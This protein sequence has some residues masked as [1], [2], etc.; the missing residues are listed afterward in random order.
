MPRTKQENLQDKDH[1]LLIRIDEQIKLLLQRLSTVEMALTNNNKLFEDLRLR[2]TKL[3][4]DVYGDNIINGIISKVEKHDKIIVKSVAIFGFIVVVFDYV[5][6][7][8][9]LR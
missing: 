8:I 6:K 3:E 7:W 2:T 4:K 1:D 9:I 5:F